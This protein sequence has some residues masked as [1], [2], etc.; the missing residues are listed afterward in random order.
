MSK[1]AAIY[2]VFDG[3]ELLEGSIRQ[4]RASCEI[5]I[6]V[7]QTIGNQ[8]EI[9][10]GG[11]TTCLSLKKQQLIDLI[12]LFEPHQDLA[13]RLEKEKRQLGIEEAKKMGCTHFLHVDCDEYY[14]T[15]QFAEAKRY[16]IEKG[17]AGTA[18]Y[19]QT[20][21]KYPHWQISGLDTYYVPFIHALTA[22]TTCGNP[23]YPCHVDPTRSVN[24][25]GDFEL[26]SNDMC[27]MH[28]YSWVRKNIDRKLANS[29]A[30]A[31]LKKHYR[32]MMAEYNSAKPGDTLQ[33]WPNKPIVVV[34]NTFDI[35]IVPYLSTKEEAMILIKFPTR[36]RSR[37][38]LVVLETY[39]H[40]LANPTKTHFLISC[41]TDDVEMN[42]EQLKNNLA[43]YKN[44]QVEYSNNTNK[45]EAVN[46]NMDKAPAYDILLL[47]SDDMIPQQ[48]GYDQLI[49][50]KMFA[51]FPDTD[52]VL[53]FN[54]GVQENRLNTLCI[55]GRAYYERFG[56]IYHPAYKS[57]WCDNEFTQVSQ[58]LNKT[59]YFSEVLIKHEH[60]STG[61]GNN[62]ALYER[63]E[64][65][66]HEDYLT[67]RKRQKKGF[68]LPRPSFWQKL[69]KRLS[70]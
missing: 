64:A 19:M 6:A 21:Y 68:D 30:N 5:I 61:E 18:L 69:K 14:D 42:N 43:K 38:F 10:E 24:L 17:L 29:S 65:Y 53:W 25:H 44:V 40:L 50:E 62:D 54:D 2:N 27:I 34:E 3:E 55:L 46:A 49:R 1:L 12:I 7:V 66:Q 11:Y 48:A 16:C 51:Y 60:H 35:Q 13:Q 70:K 63:N 4:I 47:A 45:I 37:K 33:H 22:D 56:Y 31:Y 59:A 39:M 41:D 32:K 20:Y 36:A 23:D 52:G 67:F 8:G 9:H 28:H 26:L 58:H 57:L 15:L